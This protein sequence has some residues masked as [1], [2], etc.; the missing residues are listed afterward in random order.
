V[1]YG[2]G[3]LCV[4]GEGYCVLRV[5]VTVCYGLGLFCIMG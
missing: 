1:C 3:L 4:T 5:R 2:L